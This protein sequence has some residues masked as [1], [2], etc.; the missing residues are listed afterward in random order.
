MEIKRLRT[1]DVEILKNLIEINPLYVKIDS[2][3][4]KKLKVRHNGIMV[5]LIN[6]NKFGTQSLRSI[7]LKI[8]NN[9]PSKFKPETLF[10]KVKEHTKNWLGLKYRCK[11][12]ISI[13]T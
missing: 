1:L 13:W 4:K 5:K 3:L 10:S 7:G 11:P 6:A 2:R 8:W 12:C 9:L